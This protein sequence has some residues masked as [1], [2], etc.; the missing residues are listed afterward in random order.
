MV[1]PPD[2]E[3]EKTSSDV[4]VAEGATVRLEC[5]ATGYPQPNISW[6][7]EDGG[8]I[9]I[10]ELSGQKSKGETKHEQ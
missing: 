8:D 5:Y 1:I 6:K 4:M 10:R 9:V 7:R 2:F 3:T